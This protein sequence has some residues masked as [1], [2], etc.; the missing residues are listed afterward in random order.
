MD[1]VLR[2]FVRVVTMTIGNCCHDKL[3]VWPPIVVLGE[4]LSPAVLL[5][6]VYASVMYPAMYN[7]SLVLGLKI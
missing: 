6:Y 1:I 4:G 3:Q 7:S 5:C 2:M